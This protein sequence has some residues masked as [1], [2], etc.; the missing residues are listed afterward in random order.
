MLRKLRVN[1]LI[2]SENS[3]LLYIRRCYPGTEYTAVYIKKGLGALRQWRQSCALHT[4]A[5]KSRIWKTNEWAVRYEVY[6]V[7]NSNGQLA[8]VQDSCQDMALL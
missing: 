6:I 3:L 2:V 1:G 7:A 5:G 8:Q 4:C